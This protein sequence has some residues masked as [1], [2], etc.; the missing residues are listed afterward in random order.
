[1]LKDIS[2][3][4]GSLVQLQGKNVNKNVNRLISSNTYCSSSKYSCIYLSKVL[5]IC[6][7]KQTCIAVH[8]QGTQ[9]LKADFNVSLRIREEFTNMALLIIQITTGHQVN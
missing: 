2:L 1:M 9:K 4:T 3:E 7:E 8:R 6:Y 5:Y